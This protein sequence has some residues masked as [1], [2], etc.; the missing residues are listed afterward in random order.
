[1]FFQK[2]SDMLLTINF[3]K[4]TKTTKITKYKQRVKNRDKLK[5]H[6][7]SMVQNARNIK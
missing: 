4:N 2:D 1:V 3:V 5:H 7:I 6:A